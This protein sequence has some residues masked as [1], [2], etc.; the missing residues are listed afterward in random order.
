MA[1]RCI[2]PDSVWQ[3]TWVEGKHGVN[4]C[5]QQGEEE[6]NWCFH[7]FVAIMILVGDLPVKVAED[8]AAMRARIRVYLGVQHFNRKKTIR[9]LGGGLRL[10][11]SGRK[12][13]LDV[14]KIL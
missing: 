6:T 10:A 11:C 7:L 1:V 8:F 4:R 12:H 5:A 13:F 14:L 2:H 9:T 3:L